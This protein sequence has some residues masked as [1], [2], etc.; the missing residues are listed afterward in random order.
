MKE[1]TG[2]GVPASVRPN[3]IRR[4]R[5][6]VQEGGVL[7][8]AELE[9]QGEG[10]A[11]QEVPKPKGPSQEEYDE[12]MLTHIPYRNWCK[13][14]VKGRGRPQAHRSGKE[15]EEP[16]VPVVSMDYAYLNEQDQGQEKRP[17]LVMKDRK[18]GKISVIMIPKKGEDPKAILLA[19]R[20]IRRL[21][22]GTMVWKSDQEPAIQALQERV[23]MS[24]GNGF[25]VTMERSPV[26]DHQANGLIEVTVQRF[27]GQYWTLQS[28]LEARYGRKTLE[29]EDVNAWMISHACDVINRYQVGEDGKTAYERHRGRKFKKEAAEF[30]EGAMAM[31]PG[32]PKSMDRR[33]RWIEG[34][35]LGIHEESGEVYIGTEDGIV[36][37]R[38]IKRFAKEEERWG[39]KRLDRI[40]GTPWEPTEGSESIHVK[41]AIAKMTGVRTTDPVPRMDVKEPQVRRVYIK[42]QDIE[43]LGMTDNCPGCLAAIAGSRPVGHT[44]ECRKRIMEELE[45]EGGPRWERNLEKLAREVERQIKEDEGAQDSGAMPMQEESHKQREKEED[46]EEDGRRKRAKNSVAVD[47]H[48]SAD[49]R[50][51]TEQ[52]RESTA[53]KLRKVDGNQSRSSSSTGMDID[54]VSMEIRDAREL[55]AG[56]F[57]SR[58]A[59][60]LTRKVWQEKTLMFVGESPSQGLMRTGRV[61]GSGGEVD[62]TGRI[63]REAK[64]WIKACQDACWHQAMTGR[65]FVQ[66]VSR[67]PRS[68]MGRKFIDCL[69]RMDGRIIQG[70]DKCWV[71]SCQELAV[72]LEETPRTGNFKE[73]IRMAVEEVCRNSGRIGEDGQRMGVGEE[74]LDVTA[75]PTKGAPIFWDD[76]SGEPLDPS[77]VKDAREEELKESRKHNVY[78]KVP[79]TECWQETGKAPI[80]VRWV[81]INKGDKAHQEYTDPGWSLRK[82]RWT[83]GRIYSR[84]LHHWKQS[85]YCSQW[86]SPKESD[87][88]EPKGSQG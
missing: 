64:R 80:G 60:G 17:L 81:D 57:N 31:V 61:S 50:P 79:T 54:F 85:S 65:L 67:I 3:E 44:E 70:Q 20:E 53:G 14:C 2:S 62:E 38:T 82:S 26:K 34:I 87:S 56:P 29:E 72:L 46:A 19:A 10:R 36:K 68:G 8:S 75:M 1:T 55:E 6:C 45:K 18:R 88:G 37:V 83:N 69:E 12:H 47:E 63:E 73:C 76:M 15:E 22:Y 86:Q 74:V 59:K 58:Q 42:K 7:G 43:R 27:K 4:G 78:T 40:K 9:E 49:K 30:G 32:E 77:L 13:F 71:T 11:V 66:E 25:D 84:P 41:A 33:D 24:L 28:N 52:D 23:R 39:R 35:W 5:A 51:M 48:R 21:G 16:Q